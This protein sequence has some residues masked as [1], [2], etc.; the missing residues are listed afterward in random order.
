MSSDTPQSLPHGYVLQ[1]EKNRYIIDQVLGQG[2]F[3]ITY[4]AKFKTTY[5][6]SMGTGTGWLQVAIKEFFMRDMNVRDTSSG[7]LQDMSDDSLTS[8]YRKAFVREAH[9]LANLSHPGIVNIFEV[10][11]TNNT[12][13]IVMEYID[14]G[15]LDQLIA[16]KGKLSEKGALS[17][18]H[19]VCGAVDFMHQNKMLHLDIKPKNIMLDDEGHIRLIDF[20]LSKQ[21]TVSG[22]PESSTSIGLGT[23]GYAPIEQAERMD[24]DITF[25][26]TIDVYALGATLYKMLT[27]N[28]PPLASVVSESALDGDN[29]ISTSLTEIGISA[30]IAEIVSKAMWP[31]SKK[32]IQSVQELVHTL[33]N[34][35]QPTHNETQVLGDENTIV[36]SS[37]NESSL[38]PIT[39]D[40]DSNDD[41]S[42]FN[43]GISADVDYELN[44]D[45]KLHD[46]KPEEKGKQGKNAIAFL[47]ITISFMALLLGL[48]FVTASKTNYKNEGSESIGSQQTIKNEDNFKK[49]TISGTEN[50]HE[51]VDL[52]LSVNWA[53][54][55]IGA[56]KPWD[57]GYYYAWGET[58]TKSI[59][60]ME[61]YR[62]YTNEGISVFNFNL[63]KYNY[64]S[65]RGIVDNKT[66]LELSDDVA[67]QSWGGNWR[68]PTEKEFQEL[69]DNCTW[70]W[71]TLN[72]VKGYKVT[73]RKSGYTERSIFLPAAGY[74]NNERLEDAGSDGEYWSSS[75]STFTPS[76]AMRLILRPD[77]HD[78]FYQLRFGG[79]SV[80]PVCSKESEL[81][82][83]SKPEEPNVV[84]VTSISLSKT[85]LT[86]EEGSTS[87]L[88]VKYTPAD[89][90]D[91]NT[92]WSSTDTK[93]VTV[94]SNG[95]VTA[96]K[97]GNATIIA[98][99]GGK[100]AYCTVIVKTKP[101][102]ASQQS[103]S[104]TNT[105]TAATSSS[106]SGNGWENGHEWVDL[107]LSVKWATCNIGATKPE[108]YGDYYAWGETNT[109]S[110]Y[111]W[112][113]YRFRSSGD[114]YDNVRVSKYN[115]NWGSG[116]VI[117]NKSK[118]ESDDDVAHIKWGGIWRMA[119]IAEFEELTK[120]C[121]WEWTSQN[122]IN[123]Y[124][125]TSKMSGYT[126]HFIFLPA[127]GGRGN[128]LSNQGIEGYYWS[129][130]H[131]T[132]NSKDAYCLSFDKSF[133]HTTYRI[134]RECGRSV[135]PVCP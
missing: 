105:S 83:Y 95:K 19:E 127:A 108:G 46:E 28:T 111:I 118:L 99:C 112:E 113:N 119:T 103:T 66:T 4:L 41:S 120:N 89:A 2:S 5:S 124:R 32:R 36:L 85:S 52:G 74:P 75:L 42:S 131:N 9:N 44:S 58:S 61:N 116:T 27:G 132:R 3:G 130:S 123:G 18:F 121:T 45:S 78:I 94:N 129:S 70:T 49:Y 17:L 81:L 55:N 57:Y 82:S 51:F 40:N 63:S 135:R 98:K 68:M 126:N 13:Y 109:K 35:L 110:S 72:N 20:G 80:R 102:P 71:T 26:P 62:F 56:T 90:T 92:T 96:V 79:L 33:N 101:Q 22:E 117:D 104:S 25:R 64:H 73:S 29:I 43:L 106:S 11:E 122:G 30:E 12:V 24:N 15:N 47:I 91:K 134:S 86:L 31:S 7:C 88:N 37:Q 23:P 39:S 69:K 125:I 114:T 38:T 50:G 8:K 128:G 10:I 77:S 16:S 115:T 48:I 59:Y 76:F 54:C 65:E 133:R 93:V 6:G 84:A 1:G 14:G 60:T 87:T 107:G 53:T 67:C 97:A 100:E 34:E 21:Y